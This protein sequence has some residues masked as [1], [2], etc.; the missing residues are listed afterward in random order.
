LLASA[1]AP[2]VAGLDACE[3]HAHNHSRPARSASLRR[4]YAANA[5]PVSPRAPS[6]AR[7]RGSV[8]LRQHTDDCV[9]A[10]TAPCHCARSRGW[11]CQRILP[12]DT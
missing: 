9:P 3:P 5:R 4:H 8:W 6:G 2:L 10:H 12:S 11:T 7:F 1:P